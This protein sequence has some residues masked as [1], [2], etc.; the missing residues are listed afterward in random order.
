M[1]VRR[2]VSF[3]LVVILTLSSASNSAAQ[4]RPQTRG[5]TKP[6]VKLV[7][8]IVIDQFRT[9]YLVRFADQFVDGGFRRMLTT[10]A[11]FANAA[12]IHT[13][14]YTACGH[15]TF[16]TGAT[17]S[18][19][20]IVGNEWF[21]RT[22]NRRVTSVS[23]SNAK[24]VGGRP[25]AAGMSPSRLV[26]DTIG[27]GLRFATAGKAK[28]VGISY[29]DRSAI[30]PAGKRPN[31]AYWYDASTGRFVTST[32]Y[33]PEMPAWAQKFN[34]ETRP[35][36]FFGKKWERLLPAEAY[37]RS[38]P[39][40]APEEPVPT[41]R[42][43]PYTIDGG[44]TAPGSKFYARFEVTPFANEHLVEFAKAAIDGE[45]L[46]ADDVTDLLTIS[47]SSN[48]L[49]GHNYGPYSQEVQ[50]MTLRTDRL[51]ASL[52]DY[53]D[54]RFG[55]GRTL[56]VLTADHG[57]A[58]IP[59]YTRGLGYGGR[60]PNR[61]VPETVEAELKAKFGEGPWVKQWV[62]SNLYID[63]AV[64]AKQKISMA[65]VQRTACDAIL[66]IEGI[67]ACFT[68][69]DLEGRTHPDTPV[70]RSVLRGF[71]PSRSGDVIVV[72][73]PYYFIS[74]ALG[75]THGT[76]YSY[77]TH[78]PIIFMGAGVVKG[79]HYEDCSPADIA[80]TLAAILGIT[81]PSNAEGRV[82]IS[83]FK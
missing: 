38:R 68:R 25:D 42:T 21:D 48:D 20:G 55:A 2:F 29:K 57:V 72:P 59:E 44:E 82:L 17:P 14:T 80:P 8:G 12:Y 75:T 13:P 53:L 11:N 19:N 73:Q 62:N 50:D 41:A 46:G 81:P 16:M 60:V 66:K 63:D 83:A 70:A 64:S 43:F 34:Q 23:D 45:G 61:K 76:P 39:D 58:P 4:N 28:V 1:N 3:L 27:D 79:T 69:A 65:E 40:D 32:Y 78:V 67:A 37:S 26:G 18:M 33:F 51:F 56:V 35:D 71:F 10:G 15:A 6:A 7:V 77:D 74:E 36:R 22:A 5:E 52:F 54:K 47:F 9:D 31:G 30:L 24:L 49:V